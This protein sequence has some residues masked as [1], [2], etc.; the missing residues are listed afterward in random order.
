[1]THS[2]NGKLEW[3][4]LIDSHFTQPIQ[5]QSIQAT[6]ASHSQ[7]EYAHVTCPICL[8]APPARM[9][10]INPLVCTPVTDKGATNIGCSRRTA[11]SDVTKRAW[12]LQGPMSFSIRVTAPKEINTGFTNMRWVHNRS[13]PAFVEEILPCRPSSVFVTHNPEH[14]A[15]RVRPIVFMRPLR[16]YVFHFRHTAKIPTARSFESKR[17]KLQI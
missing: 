14:N 2:D 15:T 4:V 12:I 11:K 7:V 13:M 16:V 1:M 3:S 5:S 8:T 17:N 10:C 6:I 9:P